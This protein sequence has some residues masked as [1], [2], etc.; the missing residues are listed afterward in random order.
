VIASAEDLDEGNDYCPVCG[1]AIANDPSQPVA[2]PPCVHCGHRLWFVWETWGDRQVF[3]PTGS[4]LRR[5]DL[6]M[7]LA[8][9]TLTRQMRFVLDL[10]RV[11]YVTSAVLGTLLQLHKRLAVLGGK[12]TISRPSTDVLQIFELCHLDMVLDIER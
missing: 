6:E 1:A 10:S 11:H 8:K 4:I 7:L 2:E 3:R 9:V 5:E 12:L